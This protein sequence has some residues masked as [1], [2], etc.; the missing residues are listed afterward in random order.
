MFNG[1][2]KQAF[3]HDFREMNRMWAA[4]HKAVSSWARDG[5]DQS[6]GAWPWVSRYRLAAEK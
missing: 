3:K 6:M 5:S 1:P 2:L 4:G